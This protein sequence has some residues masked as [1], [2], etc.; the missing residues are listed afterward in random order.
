MP[1]W[2]DAIVALKN[3]NLIRKSL[4]AIVLI[5]DEDTTLP[6]TLVAP[7]T[8]ALVI[9]AGFSPFGWHSDDGLSWAREVENSELSAHGSTD[10][11]R[12]DVRR[13]NNTLELTAME[14]NILTLGKSMGIE[15]DPSSGGEGEVVITEPNTPRAIEFPLL[16]LSFD[17][18]E[19]GELYWGKLFASAKVTATSPGAWSDGDNAQTHGFTMQGFRHPTAGFTVQHFI[20]GP[21]FA[22][23]REVMG[24]DAA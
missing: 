9:P 17:D 8:H 2:N 23:L 3:R 6:T 16:A 5:G 11:V 1:T 18:T 20:G 22:G 19:F 15:I 4:D 24:W 7:T 21:G 12:T 10:P 14:T 13:V